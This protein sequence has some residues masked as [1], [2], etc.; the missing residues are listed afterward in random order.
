LSREEIFALAI[1]AL[2]AS[3]LAPRLL[4]ACYLPDETFRR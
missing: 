1:F 2:L 3:A 4:L